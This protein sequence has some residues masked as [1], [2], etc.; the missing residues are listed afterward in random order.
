MNSTVRIADA[1]PRLSANVA[2]RVVAIRVEPHDAPPQFCVQL[3]DGTG[4]IDA[5]FM[6]RRSIPGIEPGARISLEGTV[7]AAKALPRMFNPRY[8]LLAPS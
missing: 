5:V 1:V 6:G 4:R 3:D 7:C 8:E 2:G